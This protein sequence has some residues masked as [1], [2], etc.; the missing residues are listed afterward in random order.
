MLNLRGCRRVPVKGPDRNP[1]VQCFCPL[2]MRRQV[3]AASVRTSG[4]KGYPVALQT[5]T[6]RSARASKHFTWHS[7]SKRNY[8]ELKRPGAVTQHVRSYCRGLHVTR[9]LR[10]TCRDPGSNRGP[11][12]LQ[13]DALPIELSRLCFE[14]EAQSITKQNT[15]NCVCFI[16]KLMCAIMVSPLH[17]HWHICRRLRLAPETNVCPYAFDLYLQINHRLGTPIQQGNMH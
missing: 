2:A 15:A 1:E 13:S 4:L 10:Q 5:R 7:E 9:G 11:S 3:A 8:C 14:F 16:G 6:E 12:D 17:H